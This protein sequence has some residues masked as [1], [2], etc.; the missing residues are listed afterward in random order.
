MVAMH[1]LAHRNGLTPTR[2]RRGALVESSPQRSG[3]T[4][5]TFAYT[6]NRVRRFTPMR[7]GDDDHLVEVSDRELHIQPS[8]IPQRCHRGDGQSTQAPRLLNVLSELEQAQPQV[9]LGVDAV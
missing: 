4:L 7:I 8:G 2:I 3:R 6:R 5:Q 1:D 9:E